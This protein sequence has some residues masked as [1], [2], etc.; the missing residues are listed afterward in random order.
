MTRGVVAGIDLGGT[1]INY[2]FL[3]S[4]GRFLI[5]GLCEHPARSVEGPDVCLAQIVDGLAIDAGQAGLELSDV[6]AIGL[7]TPGPASADGVLSRCGAMWP[8]SVTTPTPRA[9]QRSSEPGSAAA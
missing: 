3:D 7:D 5:E 4:A 1:A 9:S 6:A 2:T 8:C